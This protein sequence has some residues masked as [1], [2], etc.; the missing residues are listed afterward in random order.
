MI[1]D[2]PL[3]SVFNHTLPGLWGGS[4]SAPPPTP[5]IYLQMFSL[6]E[7]YTSKNVYFSD[8]HVTLM[9]YNHCKKTPYIYKIHHLGTAIFYFKIFQKCQKISKFDLQPKCKDFGRN[10]SSISLELRIKREQHRIRI[11]RHVKTWLP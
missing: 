6:Y 11:K 9:M 10:C 5:H 1:F 7:N 4:G 2:F 8:N 3:A